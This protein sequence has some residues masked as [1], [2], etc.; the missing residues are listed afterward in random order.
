MSAAAPLPPSSAGNP[1]AGPHSAASKPSSNGTAGDRV[2]D[3]IHDLQAKASTGYNPSSTLKTLLDIAELGLS[4]ATNLLTYRRP[5]LAFVEFT[6]S[7]EIATQVIPR[8]AGY[9]DLVHDD[10][11]GEQRLK[12]L[13]RRLFALHDQF[14]GIKGIIENNN[15]R[16][17]TLPAGSGIRPGDARQNGEAR[18][19]EDTRAVPSAPNTSTTSVN[20]SPGGPKQRPVPSPKPEALHGRALPVA[21]PNVN[22]QR[23]AD[24][25]N[26]LL[27][28]FAKLRLNTSPS[29]AAISDPRHSNSPIHS[30]PML[31][32]S[33][34]DFTGRDA[35]ALAHSPSR[36]SGPRKLPTRSSA[37]MPPAKL[38]LDTQLAAALPK[39]PSPT[40]SPARNMETNGTIAPPRHS[41][42]SLAGNDIRR[43]STTNS[44]SSASAR[45]PN[46]P[47]DASDGYFPS[48][49]PNGNWVGSL[50]H[51]PKPAQRPDELR[52]S[53]DRLYDHL[54]RY[55]VLLIDVRPRED[56][57][58]GHVFTRN[59][60][61]IEP[62]TLRQGMSAEE[63]LETLVLS[64]EQEQNMWE[65][66]NVFDLVVYYDQ[67]TQSETYLSHPANEREAKLNYLH[68][69]LYDFNQEKP[70]RA[71]PML[72]VGGLE[73]WCDVIGPQSLAVSTTLPRPRAQKGPGAI[74]RRPLSTPN[75]KAELKIPKRRLRDYNPLDQEEERRWIERARQES[76]SARGPP[77]IDEDASDGVPSAEGEDQVDGEGEGEAT[78]D[79]AIQ[80]FLQRFPEAG[81]IDRQPGFMSSQLPVRIPPPPP[82]KIPEYPPTQPPSGY[83]QVP[84]RPA[85]AAP[86]MSYNGVSDRATTSAAR[87]S[88]ALAP[89][90]PPKY[91]A[92]NQRLPRTGLVNFGVTCYMNATLQAL[93]ATLPLANFFRDDEFRKSVQRENWKGSKGVLPQLYSNIIHSLW[94]GDVEVIKPT[95]FRTFCGRLNREWGI[96]RQQDAKEF[97]DF[98]VDCLHEDL[99]SK[100]SET[101]YKALTELEE[102]RREAMPRAVVARIE[103]GRYIHREQSFLTSLFGGQHASRLRC[104]TCGFTSTT[105]EAFYSISVEVARPRSSSGVVTLDEC[106][107]SYCSE[108]MLSGDEVW[109]CPHCRRE[110]EA[111]KQITITRAPQFLVVHFKRFAAGRS[112]TAR[113]VRT[114]IDFPLR[115]FDLEPYMLP[116][117][118]AEEAA[119]IARKYNSQNVRPELAMMP[120]Y[121]YDAYAVMRH[122]GTTLTSGHYTCA[123]KDVARKCWR[124]FN[125]TRVTDFQPEQL[126]HGAALT[127]EEAYIVFYQRR[128]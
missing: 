65:N 84:A 64:P 4:Q 76:I 29:G 106:L 87:S 125:D 41:A 32:P 8:H 17:G 109:K 10:R 94:Q 123:V 35:H 58:L 102:Q 103:W 111:T 20:G 1:H 128:V 27:D 9:V 105:Y 11:N 7:F 68:A 6:R 107:R 13:C 54:P 38:P 100:W 16:H 52:I 42:R 101:P 37:P 91:M 113:K 26:A 108:E 75:G 57:D 81:M 89:Y 93:S 48:S 25:A 49:A 44:F 56:F 60:M 28:R 2:F 62:M 80:E 55:S 40:Y 53:A 88:A 22:G 85:P 71:A 43:T 96:D 119:E 18:R 120:P 30:S 21:T 126:G 24:G 23:P 3:H 73:A 124:M 12:V 14:M 34:G 74:A 46:G 121:I 39:A 47:G 92:S 51:R 115:G 118:S 70:L 97:F 127:N 36:P 45:A 112:T 33:A 99:N 69:A 78:S 95:T 82:A 66:R 104:I 122:I 79:A 116:Q 15:Q 114:P 90:I 110:R 72:L 67:D 59:T 77:R 63:L 117:P 31:M 98:L 50:A 61:C 19:E 83:T 86:R 5:D